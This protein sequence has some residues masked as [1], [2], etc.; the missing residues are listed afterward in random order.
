MYI[1]DILKVSC[2][3]VTNKLLICYTIANVVSYI[4]QL[5]SNFH[6]ACVNSW[7]TYLS[8]PCSLRL[9]LSATHR[10][11]SKILCMLKTLDWPHAQQLV[12]SY[13]DVAVISSKLSPN[14]CNLYQC[15]CLYFSILGTSWCS[16]SLCDRQPVEWE[17]FGSSVWF[18]YKSEGLW[19]NFF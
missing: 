7:I 16:T 6:V 13:I 18:Y 11:T 4:C 8:H 5:M 1:T 3:W 14:K 19:R 2:T 12:P 9:N 10:R 17:C 15:V